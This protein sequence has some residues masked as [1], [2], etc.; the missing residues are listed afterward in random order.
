MAA[1]RQKVT[2]PKDSDHSGPINQNSD[3][4]TSGLTQ[5]EATRLRA[6]CEFDEI[7]EKKV[8]PVLNFLSYF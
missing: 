7:A 8:N 3:S 2:E 6:Q 5:A 1:T 4:P